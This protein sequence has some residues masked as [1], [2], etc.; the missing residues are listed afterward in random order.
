MYTEYISAEESNRLEIRVGRILD[1]KPFLNA[2][3]P[4]YKLLID[5]GEAGIKKS[6][7]Q[8]TKLYTVDDLVGKQVAA[9]M[10][11][12]PKQIA[13]FISEVLVLGVETE[14][15]VVLLKLDKAVPDGTKISYLYFREVPI[16]KTNLFI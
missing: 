4:A 1:A 3:K 15:G 9:V 6:S 14:E 16:D 11:L 8:I 7:A 10:N 12:S 2:R 5:F 13:D